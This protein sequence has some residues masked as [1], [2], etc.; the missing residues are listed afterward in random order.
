MGYC[1]P[2]KS[3]GP[4]FPQFP[5]FSQMSDAELMAVAAE[6]DPGACADLWA[7]FV[8]NQWKLV[9]A[10]TRKDREYERDAAIS[11]FRGREFA[12]ICGFLGADA[13]AVRTVFEA[14]LAATAARA[15]GHSIDDVGPR[16]LHRALGQSRESMRAAAAARREK[17]AEVVAAGR[18]FVVTE[19]AMDLGVSPHVI[20]NDLA[21]LRRKGVLA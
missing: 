3:E 13:E 5:L 6:V 11:W 17:V 14:R 4:Q 7:A 18:E 10:P 19:L 9:F 1:P 8:K 16:N 2:P 20:H 21:V 12:A 15:P